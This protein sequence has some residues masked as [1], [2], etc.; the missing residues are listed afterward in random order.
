MNTKEKIAKIASPVKSNWL[1]E[2]KEKLANKEPR[3]K[4]WVLGVQVL[5]A[6]REQGITQ[7]ELAGRMGVSRQQVTKIV[8]GEENFTFETVEKIEKALGVPLVT[9]FES[10]SSYVESGSSEA[11]RETQAMPEKKTPPRPQKD[12]NDQVSIGEAIQKL[13]DTD[14]A[15]TKE[16]RAALS[17]AK[18]AVKKGQW[19]EA[20]RL[21]LPWLGTPGGSGPG[22]R[23]N[24]RPVR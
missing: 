24:G 3:K 21:M 19:I 4:A 7:T 18:T 2:A 15:L 16:Q 5:H 14:R 8:K 17:A 6:L 12:L 11:K 23:K 9:I 13:L 1:Q 20:I 10:G 22:R